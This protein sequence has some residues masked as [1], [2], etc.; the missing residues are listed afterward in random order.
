MGRKYELVQSEYPNL[1]HIRALRDFCDVREGDVGGLVA[2][3][4]NLSHEGTCWIFNVARVYGGARVSGDAFV[5]DMA[6]VYGRAQVHGRAWVRGNAQVFGQAVVTDHAT[7]GG[8]AQIYDQARVTNQAHV[9]GTARVYENAVVSNNDHVRYSH[10][11]K[12]ISLRENLPMSIKCQTGLETINGY[13]YAYKHVREDLSS[14][15]D[16]TFVYSVGEYVE[17]N[18]YDS[19][20]LNACAAGLHVSNPH[21]WEGQGGK[22]VLKVQVALSDILSVQTGKI[23]CKRLYVL[24]VCDS[25]TF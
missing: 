5:S 13:V 6:T 7:I 12:N 24:G 22:K 14:L 23:R 1:Y 20:P 15:Y 9:S 16:P 8:S 18:E 3:E 19:N 25:E 11:T 10:C 2:S 4:R 17:A 21:Y